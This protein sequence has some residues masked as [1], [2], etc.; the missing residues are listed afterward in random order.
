MPCHYDATA[1]TF[2]DAMLCRRATFG[3][4]LHAAHAYGAMFMPLLSII[5]YLLIVIHT[6][7]YDAARALCLMPVLRR[8][9]R[10]AMLI[11][12]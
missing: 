5:H 11:S 3:V 10:H 8:C 6:P 4:A 1:H 12:D 7:H 9:C 2:S